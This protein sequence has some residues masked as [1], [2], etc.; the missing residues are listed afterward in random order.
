MKS[1]S[2]VAAAV[3]CLALLL[4]AVARASSTGGIYFMAVNETMIETTPANMPMVSGGTL[5]VPYT[6]LSIRETG[7]RLG[8]NAQYSTTRRTVLVSNNQQAVTFDVQAN[9]AYDLDGNDVGARATVRNSMVFLPIAWVCEY[10]G[11][12]SYSTSRTPYGTLVRV[13]NSAAI[14]N[15]AALVDAADSMLRDNLAR[16]EQA[17]GQQQQPSVNPSA[18]PSPQPEDGPEVCL[19]LLWEERAQDVARQL[20][21]LGHRGLFLFTPRQLQEQGEAVRRLAA[22]GHGIGLD[23]TGASVEQCVQQAREGSALLSDLA[24]CP[25][26]IV[27]ADSLSTEGREQ[28]AQKGW[29]V[30]SA[31]LRAQDVSGAS[32]LL[33]QLSYGQRNYVECVCSGQ[34]LSLLSAALPSLA[35]DSYR[36]YQ[37]VAPLL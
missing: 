19:A 28:L 16:Y 31:T 7:V 34:Q 18:S 13:T 6:M 4:G 12:I 9:T 5:Y 11:S 22:A 37:A 14:L 8:V 15:D 36:L 35:S 17:I 25:V 3:L 33:S 32:Q 21:A 2:R 1:F 27:R 30:W 24:H 10:F 20:E 23:L 29:A 26:Y